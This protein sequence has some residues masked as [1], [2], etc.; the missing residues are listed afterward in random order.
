M[1]FNKAF[2]VALIISIL[3]VLLLSYRSSTTQISPTIENNKSKIVVKTIEKEH[4]DPHIVTNDSLI[5]KEEKTFY[6]DPDLG[7]TFPVPSK[8]I[9]YKYESDGIVVAITNN[10]EIIN[11]QSLRKT[12]YEKTYIFFGL[13]NVFSTTGILC[14][15]NCIET[16]KGLNKNTEIAIANKKHQINFEGNRFKI[17]LDEYQIYE[18]NKY[19]KPLP[20][21]ITVNLGGVEDMNTVQK[22]L[23]EITLSS[24]N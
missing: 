13:G 22:I 11:N 3:L 6:F 14:P 24:G 4:F 20:L 15:N 21:P 8:W 16:Q 23:G 2:F 12:N 18:K 10:E 7:I 5:E 17:L 1:Y 19:S 9:V